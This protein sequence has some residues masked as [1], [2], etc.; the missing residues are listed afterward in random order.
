MINLYGVFD[1]ISKKYVCVGLAENHQSFIR[2]VV[3]GLVSQYPLKDLVVRKLFSDVSTLAPE[4]SYNWSDY[5]MPETRAEALAPL[6]SDVVG[7]VD[8]FEKAVKADM[9]KINTKEDK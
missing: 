6:G 4:S 7:A 3:C 8:A 5:K 2:S 1:N 9:E